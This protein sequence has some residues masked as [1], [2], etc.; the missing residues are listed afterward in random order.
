MTD[1]DVSLELF[2]RVKS[3]LCVRIWQAFRRERH[4]EFEPVSLASDIWI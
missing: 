4:D 1:P 2:F 3:A